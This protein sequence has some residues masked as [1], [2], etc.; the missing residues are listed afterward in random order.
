MLLRLPPRGGTSDAQWRRELGQ[1]CEMP[2]DLREVYTTLLPFRRFFIDLAV[3][4]RAT[5][6]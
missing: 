3:A 1:A 6:Q 5:Q 2:G 4:A